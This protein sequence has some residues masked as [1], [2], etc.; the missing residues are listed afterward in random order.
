MSKPCEFCCEYEAVCINDNKRNMCPVCAE[1][2]A[3]DDEYVDLYSELLDRLKITKEQRPKL[4][5]T[6]KTAMNAM[7]QNKKALLVDCH[8]FTAILIESNMP[9]I[10]V[11]FMLAHELTH[12]KISQFT[13]T[14]AELYCNTVAHHLCGKTNTLLDS[15][16]TDTS[17]E[18]YI[19]DH[20]LEKA[21]EEIC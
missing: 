21:L 2:M 9:K 11:K 1:N 20:G 17:L 10:M 5:I 4:A 18:Q 7:R 12:V 19:E 14:Q 6:T 16:R 13:G 15:Y 8:G 3:T